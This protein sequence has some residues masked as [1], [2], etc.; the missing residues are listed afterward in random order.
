[1]TLQLSSEQLQ[2]IKTHAEL[3]YPDECCGLLLGKPDA[4]CSRL[5][6][7]WA[8]DNAWDSQVAE[9]LTDASLEKSHRYWISPREMLAA[10]RYARSRDLAIIGVYHSHPDHPAVPSECDQRF[11]WQQYSY[12]IVSVEHGSAIICQ[13]WLLDDRHHFQLEPLLIVDSM[14]S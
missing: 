14:R 9:E 12:L 10:M 5:M 11:A 1:M 13:S 6:E 8:T 7:L 3:T 4:D 2:A